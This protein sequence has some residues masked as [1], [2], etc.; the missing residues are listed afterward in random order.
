MTALSLAEVRSGN[1]FDFGPEVFDKH[2]T[3]IYF[4]NSG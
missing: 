3:Q 1:I 4:G 2:S